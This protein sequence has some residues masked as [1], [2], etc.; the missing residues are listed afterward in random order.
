MQVYLKALMDRVVKIC[1]SPKWRHLIEG[2]VGF[3]AFCDPSWGLNALIIKYQ[4]AAG[5]LNH[6]QELPGK[7]NEDGLCIPFNARALPPYKLDKRKV[8]RRHHLRFNRNTGYLYVYLGRTEG[9]AE[10]GPKPVTE[11]IHR[12]ITLGAHGQRQD[13]Q[14]VSHTCYNKWCLSPRC[15][16][17]KSHAENMREP[18]PVLDWPTDSEAEEG[19]DDSDDESS[20]SSSESE[21]EDESEDSTEDSSDEDPPEDQ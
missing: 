13:G 12:I 19:D 16:S 7:C 21:S 9:T 3:P 15:M 10:E 18:L 4:A 14:E 11:S 1:L 20:D 8:W 5:P 2:Q 17:W 6:V